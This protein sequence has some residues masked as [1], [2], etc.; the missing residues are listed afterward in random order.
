MLVTAGCIFDPFHA[1]LINGVQAIRNTSMANNHS[2]KSR[3]RRLNDTAYS[4]GSFKY[5]CMA[6]VSKGTYPARNQQFLNCTIQLTFLN[7]YRSFI[8][9]FFVLI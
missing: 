5:T 2:L 8:A 9:D 6:T 7:I 1:L 4:L 3:G